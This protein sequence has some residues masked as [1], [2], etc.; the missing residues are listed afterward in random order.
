MQADAL[1]PNDGHDHHDHHDYQRNQCNLDSHS[2]HSGHIGISSKDSIPFDLSKNDEGSSLA[3]HSINSKGKDVHHSHDNLHI[4]DIIKESSLKPSEVSPS[5]SIIDSQTPS[6]DDAAISDILGVG[7]DDPMALERAIFTAINEGDLDRIKNVFELYPSESVLLQMLLTTAYPNRDGFYKHDAEVTQDAQELLGPSMEHL[8]AIQIACILGDEEIAVTILDFVVR[9]TDE[10]GARKVLYEFMC[11]IW[12]NGNT[13]LHLASFL[14]MSDLVKRLLELGAAPGKINERKYRPV[15]CADDDCTRGMFETVTELDHIKNYGAASHVSEKLEKISKLSNADPPEPKAQATPNSSDDIVVS[16]SK[17]RSWD[18]GSRPRSGSSASISPGSPRDVRPRRLT[19]SNMSSSDFRVGEL[20]RTQ[21][22]IQSP[23]DLVK[24]VVTE[25]PKIKKL[26]Q[27]DPATMILHLCQHNDDLTVNRCDLVRSLI[28]LDL[29]HDSPKRI[30][31]NTIFS[32]QQWLTP[33]HISCSH[34]AY[35]ITLMLLKEAHAAVNVR[36]REGWTPL[37]CASAEG[38][39]QI[40]ELL[41]KCQGVFGKEADHKDDPACADWL[42][43]FDGPIDL[44]PLNEDDEIPEDI[45]FEDKE[46]ELRAIFQALKT[47]YP[48]PEQ[49]IFEAADEDDLQD[50]E[51]DDSELESDE[52]S[53]SESDDENEDVPS[54]GAMRRKKVPAHGKMPFGFSHA[55]SVMKSALRRKEVDETDKFTGN[56]ATLSKQNPEETVLPQITVT[57]TRAVSPEVPCVIAEPKVDAPAINHKAQVVSDIPTVPTS[58]LAVVAATECVVPETQALIL[59]ASD[60]VHETAVVSDADAIIKIDESTA[61]TKVPETSV[62]CPEKAVNESLMATEVVSAKTNP[63]AASL[64]D[65]TP[66]E[67]PKPPKLSDPAVPIKSSPPVTESKVKLPN[68]SETMPAVSKPKKERE[69]DTLSETTVASTTAPSQG[70]ADTRPLAKSTSQ[71][72]GRSL[73]SI[74]PWIPLSPKSTSGKPTLRNSNAE[75]V[76]VVDQVSKIPVSSSPRRHDDVSVAANSTLH[77]SESSSHPVMSSSC[78]SSSLVLPEC[79][80]KATNIDPDLATKNN[81]STLVKPVKDSESGISSRVTSECSSTAI[82]TSTS[83]TQESITNIASIS[84]L[85]VANDRRAGDTAIIN[86]EALHSEINQ[87]TKDSH[88]RLVDQKY[89]AQQSPKIDERRSSLSFA[90]IKEKFNQAATIASETCG[91]KNS[92]SKNSLDSSIKR[93]IE[94]VRL[95]NASGTSSKRSDTISKSINNLQQGPAPLSQAGSSSSFVSSP[96][97]KHR[98]S[99]LPISVASPLKFSNTQGGKPIDAK[100]VEL[101][102]KEVCRSD[103]VL[104]STQL[105]APIS[106]ATSRQELKGHLVPIQ[107]G[108][109]TAVSP[110]PS[111]SPS[112]SPKP[113]ASPSVSP[114]PSA[115]LS[116]TTDT[117]QGRRTRLRNG[118]HS[119]P[120]EQA[121]RDSPWLRS[122]KGP[123][124]SGLVKTAEAMRRPSELSRRSSKLMRDPESPLSRGAGSIASSSPL[125]QSDHGRDTRR[126][127]STMDK[128]N[129]GPRSTCEDP[130]MQVSGVDN[131]L[132]GKVDT[133]LRV[134]SSSVEAAPN[135]TA[136]ATKSH[137]VRRLGGYSG[138]NNST[139]PRRSANM[140]HVSDGESSLAYQTSS[141]NTVSSAYALPKSSKVIPEESVQ[142]SVPDQQANGYITPFKEKQGY[143]NGVFG[144]VVKSASVKDRIRKFEASG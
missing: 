136:T 9:I 79:P 55:P 34:G 41:G 118:S 6:M 106:V 56:E 46:E 2:N 28:G 45:A 144:A 132:V 76:P 69:S 64:N 8:N 71:N 142:C 119:R 90:Q 89:P 19:K 26:V 47:K 38:H 110:K 66:A 40:V 43:P 32:P 101:S 52:D 67:S 129:G 10:I 124:S 78:S 29:P 122:S 96:L 93:S 50:D 7:L 87:D 80:P 16:H 99:M 125:Q 11:R 123:D 14:G 138:Q 135:P 140:L 30:N 25:R 48:P 49:N 108:L 74:R 128:G 107:S 31:V 33:I 59:N 137:V 86:P 85:D 120:N 109:P 15:D 24:K 63:T 1:P 81:P 60:A 133:I 20:S 58:S 5:L 104:S 22:I 83:N 112:V 82:H 116:G 35:D 65:V 13:I 121:V 37:H 36:D 57:A 84:S 73:F 97:L 127:H 102:E 39:V 70:L 21:S 94:N 131:V 105:P 103:L 61:V 117:L 27:F 143:S 95:S 77:I 139:S 62:L 72:P 53:P 75:L 54:T 88:K 91:L 134:F 98:E 42:Y 130:E 114:K 17:S 141:E 51:I 113:S 12:G 3:T 100:S 92:S 68:T 111:A 126:L 115:S 4:H 44:I 23:V 18:S